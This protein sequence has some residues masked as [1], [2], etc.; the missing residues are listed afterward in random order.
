MKELTKQLEEAN[1]G[2]AKK[3]IASLREQIAALKVRKFKE[4]SQ[5]KNI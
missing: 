1:D 2:N 3:E 5:I 4:N